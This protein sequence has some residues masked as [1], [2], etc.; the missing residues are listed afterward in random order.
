[1][2]IKKCS[3]WIKLEFLSILGFPEPSCDWLIIGI[4]GT[5]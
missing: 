4:K 2:A 3:T 5:W 1:M